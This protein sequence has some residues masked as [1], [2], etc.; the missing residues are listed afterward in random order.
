MFRRVARHT[1]RRAGQYTQRRWCETGVSKLDPYEVFEGKVT[2]TSTA[3]EI[4]DAYRELQKEYHPD[5]NPDVDPKKITEIIEAYKALMKLQHTQGVV[6]GWVGRSGGDEPPVPRSELQE[7]VY[8]PASAKWEEST[9]MMLFRIKKRYGTIVFWF[10]KIVFNV[11][12]VVR[13]FQIL[14][15]IFAIGLVVQTIKQWLSSRRQEEMRAIK[16]KKGEA[17]DGLQLVK[18]A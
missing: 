3:K 18:A 13:R 9:S 10:A 8:R 2:T 14:F 17:E 1:T 11:V 6:K 7:R 16:A 4:K 5:I 15:M 12:Q